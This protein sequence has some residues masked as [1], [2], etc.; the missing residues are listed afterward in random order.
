MLLR[1]VSAYLIFSILMTS[2]PVAFGQSN[3][4]GHPDTNEYIREQQKEKRDSDR[5]RNSKKVDEEDSNCGFACK[6]FWGTIIAGG[7]AVA[8]CKS[9]P[10]KC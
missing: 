5:Q 9:N 2:S 10:G 3:P 4:Y 1:S 6:L 8:Y 7:A